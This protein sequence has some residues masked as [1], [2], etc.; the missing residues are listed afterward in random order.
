MNGHCVECPVDTLYEYVPSYSDQIVGTGFWKKT[1]SKDESYHRCVKDCSPKYPYISSSRKCLSNC[2]GNKVQRGNRKYCRDENI[3]NGFCNVNDCPVQEFKCYFLQ[4]FT[5]CPAFTVIYNNSCVI[6]CFDDKPFIVNG[7]CVEQCPEGYVLD[8]GVCQMTCSSGRYLFNKTC[9]D[10]CPWNKEYVDDGICVSECPLPKLYQ[11]KVCVNNCSESFAL[12]GRKC[13]TKCPSG[14]F[15]HQQKCVKTCPEFTLEENQK[16]VINCSSGFFQVDN[17][18]VSTC[19]HDYYVKESSKTCV[20]MCDGVKFYKNNNVFCLNECPNKTVE[21]NSTCISHCPKRQPFLHGKSCFSKCPDLFRFVEKKIGLDNSLTYVCVE[22]CT[23]YSASI[24]NLCVDACSL[25]EVLY[26][27][28]CQE[29]CPNSDPYKVHLPANSIEDGLDISMS[30]NVT[31]Q[32]NAF[33][34]CATECPLNFVMDNGE[35]YVNCPSAN[36]NMIFNSIC[37]PHCPEKY[38]L[39]IIE[40]NKNVCTNHCVKLR[41]QQ[42]CLDQCP[43]SHSAI[44]EGECIRCSELGMYEQNQKCVNECNFVRFENRCYNKCP[45]NATYIYN[46]TCVKACPSNASTTDEQYREGYNHLVCTDKC[47][48]DK[49]ISGNNCVTSCPASKRLPFNGICMAC[50]EVGKYDDGS[51]C[52]DECPDLH[53]EFRCISNNCPND[54]AIFNKTCVADCP[55][56]APIKSGIVWSFQSPYKCT[57][58]CEK[59]RFLYKNRCVYS[60]ENPHH[61]IFNNSCVEKCPQDAQLIS[62]HRNYHN[63]KEYCVSQCKET[64]FL[65]NFTCVEKCPDGYYS[66]RQ[67]C[68]LSCPTNNPYKYGQRCVHSCQSLRV[69]MNCYDHCPHRTYQ[70]NK[71]CVQ[72]CPLIKPFK[73]NDKCVDV[74]PFFLIKKTCYEHCP[75]GLMGYNRKCLLL[76][77]DKA[78]Y[79]YKWRCFNKCPNNTIFISMTSTCSDSCPHGKLKYQQNCYDQCP[80]QAPYNFKGECVVSCDGYLYGLE[81]YKQCPP[82]L[83]V[84][85]EKCIPK[86]PEKASFVLSRNC[87]T[88]CP[89][90]HDDHHTCMRECPENTYPDGKRCKNGCP[91]SLPFK[92]YIYKSKCIEK[93]EGNE[94]ATENNRCI[95][96]SDCSSF[97]YY[98]WCFQ[99]CPSNIYLLRSGDKKYCKSLIPVYIMIGILSFFVITAISFGIRVFY[100]CNK[101]RRV[102]FLI[103]RDETAFSEFTLCP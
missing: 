12:D 63:V 17:Q 60:C 33:A 44:H 28:I 36:R 6:E 21:V 31:S 23:K 94:L 14:H 42:T 103:I 58:S 1:I 56:T 86:C 46:K 98:S 91:P 27:E 79:R 49:F 37:L 2:S 80:M 85:K 83:F 47:S 40:D 38:P 96:S 92:D 55:V 13:M 82:R 54:L 11:I 32:I 20:K 70:Y 3:N 66:N 18:C 43:N 61:F 65:F 45:Q 7:E 97:I 59:G 93:C 22:K 90:V 24:S 15:K 89:F 25:G 68:V 101:L 5:E 64:E 52:V 16:C 67:R 95:L 88:S 35:C 62:K 51:K 9:V 34:V 100:H 102:S 10:K 19:P 72:N 39:I 76:C 71:T 29:Q 84:Y 48:S 53:H 8:N 87:V 81:C 99:K 77:P 78:K 50:H 69:G 41:F 30:F 75:S 74:C 4:C 73:Y 57:E 26:E